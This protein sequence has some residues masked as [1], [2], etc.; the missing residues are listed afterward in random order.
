MVVDFFLAHANFMPLE[1]FLAISGILSLRHFSSATRVDGCIFLP[2]TVALLF[3]MDSRDHLN[4]LA[5][6]DLG[7]LL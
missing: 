7:L 4:P 1:I 3:S 6:P 5:T 2:F